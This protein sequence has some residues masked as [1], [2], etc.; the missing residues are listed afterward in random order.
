MSTAGTYN[1]MP[2]IAG[3]AGRFYLAWSRDGLILE[4]TNV[5]GVWLTRSFAVHGY[6]PRIAANS[7]KI[8]ASYEAPDRGGPIY[9]VERSAAGT[10]TG[11]VI[12]GLRAG[13]FGTWAANGRATVLYFSA[14]GLSARQQ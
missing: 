7:G 9:L 11:A 14:N 3:A 8:F 13:N 12:T 2:D 6:H 5:S 1:N 4:S 10:W